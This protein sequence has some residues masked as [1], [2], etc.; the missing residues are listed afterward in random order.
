[1]SHQGIGGIMSKNME[2]RAFLLASLHTPCLYTRA[3]PN[4]PSNL[5]PAARLSIDTPSFSAL[6]CIRIAYAQH[7][8]CVRRAITALTRPGHKEPIHGRWYLPKPQV[9]NIEWKMSLVN[10]VN[11]SNKW[12]QS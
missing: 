2:M 8:R 12:S 9:S 4:T 3:H 1:M 10:T 7:A 11:K 5:P 6:H